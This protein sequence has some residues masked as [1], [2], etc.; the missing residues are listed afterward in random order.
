MLTYLHSYL[1]T[2]IHTYVHTYRA[3]ERETYTH[4]R[5]SVHMP[6]CLY[7]HMHAC[8]CV[9]IYIYTHTFVYACCSKFNKIC[10]NRCISRA[11]SLP[12][13][14]AGSR[15]TGRPRGVAGFASCLCQD[16]S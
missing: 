3:R 4:S 2:Y 5:I 11:G 13:S 1:H 16:G 12:H 15:G 10:N 6:V 8:T 9:Y 14:P 7:V